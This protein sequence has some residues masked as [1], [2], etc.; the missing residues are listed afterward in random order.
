MAILT[1]YP[2]ADANF[3]QFQ[4]DA[5]SDWATIR[6][7]EGNQVDTSTDSLSVI[8]IY[9]NAAT[10][11][12]LFR[13]GFVFNTSAL[14]A[15]AVIISAKFCLYGSAK[16]DDISITPNINI[17]P[18]TPTDPASLVAADYS[19][20]GGAT[21][22]A[23]SS[24]ITYANWS[25]TGYNEFALNAAGLAAISLTGN[26]LIST[27]NANYDASGDTP[28]NI[29][30]NASYLNAYMV[31]KG[32]IYRPYLEIT[33]TSGTAYTMDVETGAFTLTGKDILVSKALHMIPTTGSFTLTGVNVAL[34]KALNMLTSVGQFILTGIDV[35]LRRKGWSWGT[36]NTTSYT[37]QTKNTTT[38]TYQDKKTTT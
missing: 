25:I 13:A 10:W 14:G 1:V 26:T 17:Y 36:K 2:S 27:R 3:N 15:G 4:D 8:G 6:A 22:T 28:G 35:V 11:R 24:V 21:P 7:A 9:G 5:G 33:Y 30:A 19:Q 32:T 12:R 20:T 37:D 34:N 29:A 31:E 23:Y 38:E 18:F 16:L